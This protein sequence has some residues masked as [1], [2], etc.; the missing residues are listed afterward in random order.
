MDSI[1]LSML[2][3]FYRRRRMDQEAEKTSIAALMSV[4][5]RRKLNRT[6]DVKWMVKNQ[7]Y[8][9]EV[10]RISREL[11]VADL[12]GYADHFEKLMFAPS[13]SGT[14][15]KDVDPVQSYESSRSLANQELQ[16][17]EDVARYIGH[18]R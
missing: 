8:A 15:A 6:V 17:T 3:E 7:D 13:S 11:D 18:L 16:Q 2:R 1:L 12:N 5:L 10:I 4:I 9:R 14:K